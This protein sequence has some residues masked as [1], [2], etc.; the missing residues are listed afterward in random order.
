MSGM[1]LTNEENWYCSNGLFRYIV[2]HAMEKISRDLPL[3]EELEVSMM[4]RN[5]IS[6]EFLSQDEIKILNKA[7]REVYRDFLKV[8]PE[9]YGKDVYT[10]LLENF[11]ELIQLLDKG[12]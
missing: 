5:W 12:E 8:K 6:Y 11:K 7:I 2:E 4:G 9:D 1:S 10:A 3:H